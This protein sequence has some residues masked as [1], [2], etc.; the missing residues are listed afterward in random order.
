MLWLWIYLSGALL[1]T[2]AILIPVYWE[3]SDIDIEFLGVV[4][5][6]SL[7]SYI[8]VVVSLGMVLGN[9]LKNKNYFKDWKHKVLIKGRG[10]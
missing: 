6:F 8:T 10:K 2:P 9:I 3:G 1:V 7:F 5:F 4:L